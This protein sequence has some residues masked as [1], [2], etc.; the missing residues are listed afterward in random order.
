MTGKV[1]T[2]CAA[3]VALALARPARAQSDAIAQRASIEVQPREIQIGMSYRGTKVHVEGVAPAGYRLALLCLGEESK[4][5]LKRKGKV[6]QLLWMNVGDVSFERV[7]SLYLASYEPRAEDRS[8]T[9]GAGA[10]PAYD[11][12][13]ER[14]LPARAD[15]D[16]RQ[17][18]REFIKLKEEEQLYSSGALRLD[19]RGAEAT[20]ISADFWLPASAPAGSYEVRMVGYR[21]GVSELLAS[22]KLVTRRVG[23]AH[24]ISEA[25]ERHGLLYGLLSVILAIGAGFLTGVIFASAKK[26]H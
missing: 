4:V 5:E 2:L 11:G 25:A 24:L 12:I 16:T 6:W 22:R 7:P 1:L 10:L 18:F 17:L 14:A 13:E 3:L 26:G 20:R 9:G 21:A 23:L 8:A 19:G 15:A